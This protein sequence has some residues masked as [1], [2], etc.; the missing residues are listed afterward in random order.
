MP[1]PTMKVNAEAVWNE[2][3]GKWEVTVH[4][5]NENFVSLKDGEPC[6]LAISEKVEV[7]CCDEFVIP[8]AILEAEGLDTISIAETLGLHN[9]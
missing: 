6:S 7:V 5:V 4:L 8:M 2:E 1:A 9:M 3:K